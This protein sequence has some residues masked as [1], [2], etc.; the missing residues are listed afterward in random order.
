MKDD[1]IRDLAVLLND[2]K[3]FENLDQMIVDA[4]RYRWLCKYTSQLFMVTEEQM[5]DQVDRAMRGK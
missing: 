2:D 4:K 3:T 1:P 5:N